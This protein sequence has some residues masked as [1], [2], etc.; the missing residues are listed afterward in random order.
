MSG[1]VKAALVFIGAALAFIVISFGI[2]YWQVNCRTV[3]TDSR[4]SPDGEYSITLSA[5]GEP[6]FPFG[7]AAGVLVFYRNGEEAEKQK[8]TVWDDGGQISPD[9]WSVQWEEDG[10]RVTVHGSEMEDAEYYFPFR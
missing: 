9:S 10:C 7:P 2:F 4:I 1:G 3:E 5:V 6:R 8:I